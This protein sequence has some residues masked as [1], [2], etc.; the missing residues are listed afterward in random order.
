L[1][2]PP[3]RIPGPCNV[4]K[5]LFYLFSSFFFLFSFFV[6]SPGTIVRDRLRDRFLDFSTATERCY[7]G[8]YGDHENSTPA[9][10]SSLY[11][12]RK[13]RL[14]YIGDDVRSDRDVRVRTNART[15]SRTKEGHR[16]QRQRQ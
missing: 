6:P 7:D 15:L 8:L 5:T 2:P 9:V 11:L 12:E 1:L 14:E 4:L 10:C 3:Q 13:H 16:Q